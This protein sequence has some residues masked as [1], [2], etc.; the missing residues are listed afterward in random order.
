METM[1]DTFKKDGSKGEFVM[2]GGKRI[3]KR[4]QKSLRRKSTLKNAEYS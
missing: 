2:G 3:R 1:K 4:K